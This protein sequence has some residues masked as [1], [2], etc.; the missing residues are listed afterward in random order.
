[1]KIFLI[2][3]SIVIAF[4]AFIAICCAMMSSK[5][6]REEEK[7]LYEGNDENE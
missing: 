7:R 4:F 1:M 2:C 3:L 5:C 6:T